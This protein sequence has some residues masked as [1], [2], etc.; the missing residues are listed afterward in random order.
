MSS[1]TSRA[2]IVLR[3]YA[4]AT[5]EDGEEIAYDIESEVLSVSQ[6]DLPVPVSLG[7]GYSLPR[8]VGMEVA[9]HEY[10]GS[11]TWDRVSYRVFTEAG[12]V[13]ENVPAEQDPAAVGELAETL[14]IEANLDFLRRAYEA[15][16]KN[17]RENLFPG[18]FEKT[19]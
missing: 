3:G 5:P 17:I 11:G 16:R 18:Y 15:H 1:R 10:W 12:L 7:D 6:E 2:K 8:K 4:T 14:V 19:D 9:D 13:L